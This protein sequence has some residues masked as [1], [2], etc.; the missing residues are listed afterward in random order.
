M[1]AFTERAADSRCR[2]RSLAKE[3]VWRRHVTRQAAGRLSVRE[4]CHRHDLAE[5]SFYAWRRQLA[6]RDQSV[7]TWTA[8]SSR[9]AGTSAAEDQ[10]DYSQPYANHPQ[11]VRERTLAVYTCPSRRSAAN[12][13]GNGLL[14]A[15][16]TTWITLP[17]GCKIPV[18]TTGSTV[19]SGAVGDYGG[20][21]GDLSPGAFGLPT[22]FY[23]GGNGTGTIISS[24][25]HCNGTVPRDWA[26]RIAHKDV[27]D[28]LSNT[29][30]AGEIHVPIGKLGQ[31]PEGA[32]IY[33]GDHVFNFSRVGGPTVPIVSDRRSTGN[34]LV[35]WGSWHP[36]VC[37][38][39]IRHFQA[40]CGRER[41]RSQ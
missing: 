21:H 15:T 30:L 10:W 20:N 32:F 12:A 17:C 23:Y 34:S 1:A 3:R 36:G 25:A 22:D 11:A 16:T 28:G 24:R 19:V 35:A 37:H 33:N 5:P 4:Y 14:T 39:A 9:P 40:R 41:R 7:P 6:Q 26:D 38:F 13:V 29:F 31:S 18:T 27:A 8:Q 2:A